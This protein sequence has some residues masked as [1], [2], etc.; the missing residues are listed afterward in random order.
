MRRAL[1]VIALLLAFALPVSAAETFHLTILHTNDLHGMM[2]PFDYDG[3]N[4]YL[5]GAQK[6]IGGL[7]RRATLIARL[8]R[9]TG[10]R[11]LVVDTG[12]V[13]TRGP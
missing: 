7:A 3:G 9:E 5:E 13:F 1:L 11:V 10:H 6:D 4:G 8:R 2:R 12:D